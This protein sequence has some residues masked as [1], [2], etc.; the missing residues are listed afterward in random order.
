MADIAEWSSAGMLQ[1]ATISGP[2]NTSAGEVDGFLLLHPAEILPICRRYC[3]APSARV[4]KVKLRNGVEW[5]T[6]TE[7]EGA[8][9]VEPTDLL[10]MGEE[11]EEFE[12]KYHLGPYTS[13]EAQTTAAAAA[14]NWD[15]AKYD[16][17]RFY[18]EMVARIHEEGIPESQ[19]EMLRQMQDWWAMQDPEGGPGETTL[20]RRIRPIWQRL[21][22]AEGMA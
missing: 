17:D 20:L 5:L 13:A 1:V 2:V 19:G 21:R 11:V 8:F 9:T 4:S 22:G 16:W 6:I 12:Q 10:L 3:P 7:P 14:K 18:C 15:A